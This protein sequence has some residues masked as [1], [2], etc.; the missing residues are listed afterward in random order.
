MQCSWCRRFFTQPFLCPYRLQL[1]S[2]CFFFDRLSEEERDRF[3][4]DERWWWRIVDLV[5]Q[6]ENN[7]VIKKCVHCGALNPNP[8]KVTC[9]NCGHN[10]YDRC[11][12][13][14]LPTLY[15]DLDIN[16][17][18]CANAKCF[19]KKFDFERDSARYKRYKQ[20]EEYTPQDVVSNKCPECGHR[21]RFDTAMQFWRCTNPK[22]KRIYTYE[23]LCRARTGEP[24]SYRS[25]FQSRD[26]YTSKYYS[27]NW[28][29]YEPRRK[30]SR[31]APKII[32]ITL[33]FILA[34][35]ILIAV[36]PF[37]PS[38]SVSPSS[39]CFMVDNGLNPPAETLEIKGSRGAVTWLATDN[40]QWL[41]LDPVDGSTDGELLITLSAD[42]SG[43]YPGEYAA[44]VTISAPDARNTPIKLPV[45]LVITE[46]KETLAIRETLG[47]N[48][49]NVKMLYNEQ[50]PYAKTFGGERI[51]LIN[52]KNANDPT[53]QQLV[54][55]L[56]TDKT[57]GNDYSLFSFP[58]GAFAEEVHNNAEALGIRAAWVAVDF[59]DGGELHAL[60][61]FHTTDKGIVFV[62]CTSS[63]RS[64]IVYPMISDPA[65][66]ESR[67][68]KPERLPTCDKVAYVV[69]G[70]EYGLITLDKAELPSY[71]FYE[72]YV[73]EWQDYERGVKEYNKR[74]N[75]YI[76]MLGGRTVIYN[77]SEY[78]KLKRMHDELE[79]ERVE[80]ESQR[81]IL[82]DYGWEPL[83]VVSHVEIYW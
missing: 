13:C 24:V 74:A 48:T 46:T 75:E 43:L 62:D 34:I 44:T 27:E 67:E 52:N 3:L 55:F 70:K 23:E 28:T 66:G 8:E 29:P 4:N 51:Y 35:I 39:P 60:N 42:I 73:Q 7:G 53:W 38:L 81:E 47:G 16:L 59:Q 11:P 12:N 19:G 56:T 17:W 45:S 22:H 78:R 69:I 83:G 26:T 32:G 31:K 68:Y 40:A 14:G 82:G 72:D 37:S 21:L 77:H 63:Y 10:I 71:D 33:A 61:A 65:T 20:A 18:R 36:D 58:C 80:L 1:H 6:T 2:S 49:G 15:F 64:D 25:S 79:K 5:R 30:K 50:P 41:N 9:W 54:S 76:S 57:D